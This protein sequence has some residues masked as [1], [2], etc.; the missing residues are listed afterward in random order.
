MRS[1]VPIV[2]AILSALAALAAA[3]PTSASPRTRL[4]QAG[5]AGG[6][7]EAR[8]T[9]S[10]VRLTRGDAVRCPEI[11]DDAGRVHVVSHLSPAIA[12]GARVT[13]TGFYAVTTK[14]L[15]RVLVV[16]DEAVD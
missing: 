10:G 12:I 7:G 1:L 14:C 9:I 4:A 2:L 6:A 5:P 13:V 8:A 16:E 15:G 11:R 3:A